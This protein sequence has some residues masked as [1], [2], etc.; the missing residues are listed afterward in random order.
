MMLEIILLISLFCNFCLIPYLL[1][2]RKELKKIIQELEKKIKEVKGKVY[3]EDAQ[4]YINKLRE[5]WEE[6][7]K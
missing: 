3:P 6:K 2:V 1:G 4:K 5:E 7:V